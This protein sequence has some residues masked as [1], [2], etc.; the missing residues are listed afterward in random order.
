M[1]TISSF[2]VAAALFL[3]AGSSTFAKTKGSKPT[4][5]DFKGSYTG[6]VTFTYPGF[7]N[8]SG[9]VSIVFN[10]NKSGKSASVIVNGSISANGSTLP[11]TATLALSHGSLS[12]DNFV[13]NT[14]VQGSYP[15][16]AIYLLGKR[17][18]SF[19]GSATV[20]GTTYPFSGV[21][22][23]STKGHKQKI[24]FTYS[25]TVSGTTYSYVFDVSRHVKTV[26]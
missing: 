5:S 1:K 11:A 21:I 20:M 22:Q 18:I 3:G 23:T 2:L 9:P 17:T 7:G 10:T 13:F 19:N 8:V 12:I 25:F 4:L 14:L 26:K 24:T 15:G 16:S 6:T